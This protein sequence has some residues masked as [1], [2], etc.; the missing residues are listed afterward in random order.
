MALAARLAADAAVTLEPLAT[1]KKRLPTPSARLQ[2]SVTSQ[3]IVCTPLA[4]AVVS[5]VKWPPAAGAFVKP[6][7]PPAMSVRT[8]P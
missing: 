2:L 7:N 4:S 3:P 8:S 5:N 1:V 6:A